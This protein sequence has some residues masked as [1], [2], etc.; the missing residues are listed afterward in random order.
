MPSKADIWSLSCGLKRWAP[1]VAGTSG[2][3]FSCEFQI[4]TV[5][6]PGF[7]AAA[8]HAVFPFVPLKNEGMERRLAQLFLMYTHRCYCV[9]PLGAQSRRFLIPG[10]RF[11]VDVTSL[12]GIWRCRLTPRCTAAPREARDGPVPRSFSQSPP[13]PGA[14]RDRGLRIPPAG[15]APGSTLETSP[16]DAPRRASRAEYSPQSDLS[17]M[18][19]FRTAAF[20]SSHRPWWERVKEWVAARP[21]PPAWRSPLPHRPQPWRRLRPWPCSRPTAPTRSS[22]RTE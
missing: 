5:P 22:P 4:A 20:L 18:V 12:T 21:T 8:R 16:E 6:L 17:Q 14:S 1:A 19:F 13:V 7:F 2:C 11:R 9:A 10:P 3:G 15:A